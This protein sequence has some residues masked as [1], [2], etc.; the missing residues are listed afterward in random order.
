MSRQSRKRRRSRRTGTRILFMGAGALAVSL[1]IGVLAA[2]GYVLHVADSAPALGTLHPLLSGGSSE[3]FAANGTPLGFIQSDELR[4]PIGWQEIPSD[5][6]NATISIEDQRFY[7][8]DGV[9]LTGIFRA[10]VKD[11]S[12]GQAL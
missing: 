5:V 4:T 2:V 8:N 9:D 12:E 3:V 10:A 7:K 11:L 1:L 6:K